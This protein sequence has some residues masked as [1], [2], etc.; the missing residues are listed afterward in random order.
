M[1]SFTILVPSLVTENTAAYGYGDYSR[2]K[3]ASF[4]VYATSSRK[5]MAEAKRVDPS[6]RFGGRFGCRVKEDT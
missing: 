3:W 6:L 4:G 5:A 2:T 1:K